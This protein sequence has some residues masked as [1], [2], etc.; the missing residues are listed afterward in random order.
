MRALLLDRR[1]DGLVPIAEGRELAAG[2][3]GARFLELGGED[4]LPF[5]GETGPLL[6][7]IARFA[8]SV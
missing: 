6:D 8:E 4:H 1:A 3:P 7:E 5:A 2:I